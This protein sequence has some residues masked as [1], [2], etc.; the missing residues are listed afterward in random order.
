[1]YVHVLFQVLQQVLEWLQGYLYLTQLLTPLLLL[2]LACRHILSKQL[3]LQVRNL[4]ACRTEN[5]QSLC[6]DN[7]IGYAAQHVSSTK[8]AVAVEHC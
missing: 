2:V 8:S 7:M 4:A 5:G 6:Y 1:V 3:V